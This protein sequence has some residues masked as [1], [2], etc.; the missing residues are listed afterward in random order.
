MRATT[1]RFVNLFLRAQELSVRAEAAN[2]AL[3]AREAY[4]NYARARATLLVARSGLA[5][6][7]A[8]RRDVAALVSAGT[9]ARVELLP[10]GGLSPQAPAALALEP[11][12][13]EPHYQDLLFHR[14]PFELI[15]T[16]DGISDDG[17]AATLRGVSHAGWTNFSRAGE[18]WH[19]DVAALDAGLQLAV[20]FGTRM[21]GG[22]NLPTGIDQIR[23]FGAAPS[24]GL[25]SAT[26]YRRKLGPSSMTTDIVFTDD[27]GQCVAELLGVHN[28][29]LAQA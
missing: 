3:Q 14:G 2:V 26:A 13:G 4:Y 5:Q 17:I 10:A 9:L 8:Q 19:L 21:L 29:A 27:G 6:S 24:T 20:L 25:L 15:H 18:R 28:H 22:P 11:W 1:K 23:M 7:E 16:L 12:A